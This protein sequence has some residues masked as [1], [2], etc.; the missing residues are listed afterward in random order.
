MVI[1]IKHY[2]SIFIYISCW[3][4]SFFLASIASLQSIS[5]LFH[6][7][8]FSRRVLFTFHLCSQNQHVL[9]QNTQEE[10]NREK[11]NYFGPP[12]SVPGDALSSLW[13]LWRLCSSN[14]R[15]A[16]WTSS[17]SSITRLRSRAYYII[18]HY[19]W[20]QCQNKHFSGKWIISVIHFDRKLYHCRYSAASY[21]WKSI[22]W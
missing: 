22:F 3:T 4:V 17:S 11:K 5:S 8:I 10:F 16:I 2:Q 15:F 18:V 13:K 7:G 19:E 21:L 20:F 1:S 6:G 12:L 14:C 9:S